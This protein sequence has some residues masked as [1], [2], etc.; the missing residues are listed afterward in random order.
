MNEIVQKITRP[1]LTALAELVLEKVH[2]SQN[3]QAASVIAL[4]GDLGTGKTTFVQTL[5]QVLQIEDVVTSPTFTVM[6]QYVVSQ[7]NLYGIKQLVH[8]DAYRIESIAELGPLR[9]TEILATPGIL[10]CIEW[11]EKITEVLP[12]ATIRMDF[13]S[14]SEHERLVTITSPDGRV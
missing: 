8:M 9:L 13:Q 7:Q 5:A 3:L 6:K 2:A 14:L 4:S 12:Q 11:A 10:L 1:D